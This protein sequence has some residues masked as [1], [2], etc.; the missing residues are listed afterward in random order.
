MQGGVKEAA[1]FGGGEGAGGDKDGN[2]SIQDPPR[3]G[4]ILQ[5]PWRSLLGNRKIMSSCVTQP[6]EVTKELGVAV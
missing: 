2:H 6:L 1:P 3:P 4:H 5:L